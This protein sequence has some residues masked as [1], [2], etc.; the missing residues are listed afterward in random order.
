MLL[1]ELAMLLVQ[2]QSLG[3]N[4]NYRAQRH[5]AGSQ[6]YWQ[7]RCKSA[8][9]KKGTSIYRISTNTPG[10]LGTDAE[11]TD[12]FQKKRLE[13]I[14]AIENNAGDPVTRRLS[15]FTKELRRCSHSF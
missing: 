3:P 4:S 10:H 8:R 1:N 2:E 12:G 6:T 7:A 15:T 5:F 11:P 13:R 9:K 14:Q